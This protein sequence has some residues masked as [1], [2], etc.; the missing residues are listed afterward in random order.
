MLKSRRYGITGEPLILL[1]KPDGEWVY[2]IV[3]FGPPRRLRYEEAF[4]SE[5]QERHRVTKEEAEDWGWDKYAYLWFFP[6]DCFY[7]RIGKWLNW[8]KG[9][10]TFQAS[11]RVDWVDPKPKGWPG[12]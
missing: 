7:P 1:S 4:D 3:I 11:P 9:I 2:G 5:W 6:V 10:Q 12:R 8:E